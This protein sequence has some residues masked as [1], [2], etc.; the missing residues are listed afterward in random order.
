MVKSKKEL[1]FWRLLALILIF[2]L[3]KPNKNQ[4]I[5][6]DC[7]I[8]SELYGPIT[9]DSELIAKIEQLRNN[10]QVKGLILKVNSPG[11]TIVGGESLYRAL[12]AF[13][14]EKPLYS[15]VEDSATSGAYMAILP[16]HKIFSYETSTLG[17]IGVLTDYFDFTGLMEKVGVTYHSIKSSNL[18][19]SLNPFQKTD[20]E[21]LKAMENYVNDCQVIFKKMV[22]ESRPQIK[23]LD[24]IANGDIFTGGKALDEGLIDFIGSEE[25]LIKSLKSNPNLN[26]PIIDYQLNYPLQ[27]SSDN[28]LKRLF[29]LLL[30]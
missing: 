21:A 2:F 11:G 16:S 28:P 17:S 20:P 8:R 13:A 26:L 12:K 27:E 5:N 24:S 10:P 22:Q 25:D 1:W 15:L 29:D 6:Q 3:W 14:K 7:F 18:K 9:Y 30:R 23:N 4:E 19:N